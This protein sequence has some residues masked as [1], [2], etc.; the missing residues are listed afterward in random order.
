[1]FKITLTHFPN[2]DRLD[3]MSDL[4]S[5]ATDT[6]YIYK[7]RVTPRDILKVLVNSIPNCI[8][9]ETSDNTHV[10]LGYMLCQE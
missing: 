4:G 8:V 9:T 5:L 7:D 6:S 10:D 1:M 2:M 3:V